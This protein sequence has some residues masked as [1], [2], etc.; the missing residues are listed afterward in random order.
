MLVVEKMEVYADNTPSFNHTYH[1]PFDTIKNISAPIILCGPRGNDAHKVSERLN[2]T[3]AFTEL[4]IVLEAI[5]KQ[6]FCK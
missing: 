1:I 3:S 2:K 5:I 6:Y 4:P